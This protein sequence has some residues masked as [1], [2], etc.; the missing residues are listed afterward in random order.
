VAVI[1][2]EEPVKRFAW[3]ALLNGANPSRILAVPK[4]SSV[5]FPRDARALRE[6]LEVTGTNLL[7]IDSVY[8]HFEAVEGQNAAERARRCLS[9]LAEIAQETGVTIVAI[10]HENKAGAYLGSVEMVNVA[11][12][13]LRARRNP[14]GPLYVGVEKTNLFD[15]EVSMTFSGDKVPAV[16]PD[17][18]EVQME[19]MEDGA[20]A[21][22]YF[23]TLERGEDA[24]TNSLNIDDLAETENPVDTSQLV[25]EVVEAHP[26]WTVREVAEA[27]GKGKS[28][29]G[30][31]M[32][33]LSVRSI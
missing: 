23:T 27:V 14:P 21:P 26:D 20:L 9:P 18:G 1:S 17:T 7:Y 6:C 13:V 30:E 12:Y 11:R 15:P 28:V 22:M 31:Y 5:L 24:P 29:V 4:A 32:K 19:E 2:V 8:T 25:Q 3:R 10:F 33:I 16:D